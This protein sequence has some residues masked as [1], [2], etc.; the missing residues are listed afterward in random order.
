MTVRARS[1]PLARNPRKPAF[2]QGNSGFF[3]FLDFRVRFR[4]LIN[5]ALS[6]TQFNSV[7]GK[8]R[9][10]RWGKRRTG[11]VIGPRRLSSFPVGP[12][13]RQVRQ[14]FH[15]AGKVEQTRSRVN[16]HRQ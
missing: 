7:S 15:R 2:F 8:H 3:S 14:E 10:K 11:S 16:V 13:K 1:S 4:V 5:L 6:F 12:V 9:G